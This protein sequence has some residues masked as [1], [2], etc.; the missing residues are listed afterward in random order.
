MGS[1][2][3]MPLLASTCEPLNS[4]DKELALNSQSPNRRRFRLVLR[5]GLG[6]IEYPDGAHHAGQLLGANF[7]EFQ[8]SQQL[9]RTGFSNQINL[10][11]EPVSLGLGFT[12][13]PTYAVAAFRAS[14]KIKI[15]PLM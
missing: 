9:K 13:L 8:S 3:M 11:L 12:V 14:G 10:I 5:C 2:E 1:H 15:C 4:G 7:P 6:F